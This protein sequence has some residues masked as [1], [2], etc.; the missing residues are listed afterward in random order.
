MEATTRSKLATGVML[1][2]LGLGL[3]A[4]QYLDASHRP[5][6][7]T[8]IGGLFLAAYFGTR[9]YFL[10][11]L[12]GI[13]G[14]LGVGMFGER[15]AFA[16]HEYTEIGL[17]AGFALIFL[18]RLAYERKSHWWPLVPALVLFLL[19]FHAWRE[20]RLF[21]FS[22]RGWPILIVILGALVVLGALGRG[23]KKKE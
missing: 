12:G 23:K 5:L 11:V 7:L 21:V 3:Y 22:S 16:V 19:G 13:I 9:S 2:V 18:I 14:G 10:L 20:F 15:R 4:M 8:L 17:G 6:L 1:I